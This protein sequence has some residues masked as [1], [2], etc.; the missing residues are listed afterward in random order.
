MIYLDHA[1]TTP[2][3]E[4]VLKKM[5][6]YMR[7]YYANPASQYKAGRETAL[8]LLSARDKIAHILDCKPDCLCFLSGG[9]EAGNFALKGACSAQ[10]D[11]GRHIIV[12][13]IE[14]PALIESAKDMFK[15][16]YEVSFIKPDSDGVIH[17]ETV[18]KAIRDD[19]VFCA[20]MAANNETGVIQ[21]V[22]KIGKIL[23]E[24]GVF[25]YCDC[26]QSAG[27]LPFPTR[28]CDALGISSHK[29]YGPK[30]F[31]AIYIREGAHINRLISGGKQERGLRAGTSDVA[32][33]VGCA[34]AL[35][36]AVADMEKNNKK[37]A[38]LRNK[39]VKRVLSEIE[40]THLNGGGE[41]LPSNA[42]ISFDGCEGENILFLLDM[43]DVC[44]SVGS[45]CSAGAVKASHVLEAM[46][47]SEERVKSAV[48]FT[49]GKYNTEEEVDAV[50]EEL[51]KAV[52]K[53]RSV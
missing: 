14:H 37:I 52:K 25:Y 45:A 26:V 46:N 51:K 7:E 3:D 21:P 13:A 40:G 9:T 10:T 17:P 39:F 5:L 20:V 16:G 18:E 35:E 22:E 6:P 38:F 48:R 41:R 19:T 47:L 42:N 33:A 44:V 8:A 24:R 36:A 23:R 49:F 29:F 4:N 27:V 2:L 50:L 32:S 53:I 31:G 11:K 12:S 34:E 30:G 1:A 43:Q 28:Y 15:F